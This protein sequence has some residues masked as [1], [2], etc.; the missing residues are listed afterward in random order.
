MKI[1]DTKKITTLLAIGQLALDLHAANNVARSAKVFYREA[2][3]LYEETNG[4]V[5]G[6]INP[7]EPQFAAVIAATKVEYEAYQATKRVAY[8]VQRR[9]SNA[10]RR[11]A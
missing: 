11:S 1:M 2:I 4:R 6:R 5:T 7:R 8:N 10:C 3:D 9:L